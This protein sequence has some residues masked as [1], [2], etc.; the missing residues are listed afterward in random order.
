MA[1]FAAN[2]TFESLPH[3]FVALL[4]IFMLDTFAVM[5]SGIVQPVYRSA[6]EAIEFSHGSSSANATYTTLDGTNTSLSG[7][8]YMMGLAAGDFEFDHVIEASHPSSSMFPA[9]L[10][11]A[12]AFHRS[13]KELLSAMAIGYEFATRIGYATGLDAEEGKGFHAMI[14]GDPATAAAVGNLMGWNASLIASAMGL[15]ASSSSG[16]LAWINT[17]SMTRRTHPAN[18]GQLGAI[19]ALLAKSGVVGPPNIIENEYGYLNA[20]SLN[21]QPRLLIDKLGDEWQSAEQTL[22][23]LPVHARG[24]GFAYAIDQYRQSHA[25]SAAD[26]SNI[27]IYAG[28][29]VLNS[30]NWNLEP[31]SLSS[32]Q[33]SIPFGIVASLVTDLRNP[34][35]MND[36][37]VFN[38]TAR[39]L[40][41]NIRNISISD[42][43]DYF[44]GYMT[45]N[46]GNELVNITVDGYPGLPGSDGYQQVAEDKYS[47]VLK[48][49]ELGDRGDKVKSKIA[50]LADCDD[51]SILLDNLIELGI[52]G[53]AN[54]I[55]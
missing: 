45:V 3:S 46:I 8:M 40:T 30:D 13:G 44:L 51:V 48:E 39:D 32:A 42:D 23:A 28:P 1:N 20:F 16:L 49:L 19:A 18:Q 5:L 38:Q 12:A 10:C 24:L 34:L 54:F 33:Y 22:K 6:L 29:A 14:N 41:A 15:A 25:W 26:I 27:T 9:L 43:P 47:A 21:P 7:Q 37:L 2:S 35:N 52:A 53:S 4:S 31:G 55:I 36:A 11:V 50:T 17:E